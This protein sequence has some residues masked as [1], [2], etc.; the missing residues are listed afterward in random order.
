MDKT[1]EEKFLEFIIAAIISTTTT[2]QDPETTIII[3]C[4]IHVQ[5]TFAISA[6]FSAFQH[7]LGHLGTTLRHLRVIRVQFQIFEFLS[8]NPH[9]GGYNRM[10][11]P[12]A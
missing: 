8:D 12:G 11:V 7:H 3:A 1:P 5:L 9:R 10:H 4:S 2:G 6:P